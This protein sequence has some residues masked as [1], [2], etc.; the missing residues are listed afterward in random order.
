MKREEFEELVVAMLYAEISEGER[1]RLEEWLKDH[2]HDRNEFE[3][4]KKTHKLMHCLNE[5]EIAS[6]DQPLQL[7]VGY[8]PNRLRKRW[9]RWFGAA[10]AC[11]A[12]VLLASTQGVEVQIGKVRMALGA[13]NN[14]AIDRD[15]IKK[16]LITTYLPV[17]EQLV[18]AVEKVQTAG[19]LS[20]ERLDSLERSMQYLTYYR[21][22]NQ[23]LND[24]KIE[25][26]VVGL[27]REVDKRLNH[28]YNISY[29]PALKN[30]MDQSQN[31][32]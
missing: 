32:G 3:E 20:V 31:D 18:K 6:T 8:S 2:P 25:K 17:M 9:R 24:Q 30:Q 5:M 7:P 28:L 16:E 21:Q 1:N 22:A 15:E 26:Y 13:V 12:F 29:N 19:E 4:L 11:L 10:A 27:A 23:K 14:L